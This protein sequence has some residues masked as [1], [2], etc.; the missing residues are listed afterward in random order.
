V[1]REYNTCISDNNKGRRGGRS[2]KTKMVKKL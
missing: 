2:L 1:S